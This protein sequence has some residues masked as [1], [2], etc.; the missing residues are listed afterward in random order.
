MGDNKDA[1]FNLA[2]KLI[3]W[4]GV[5]IFLIA[6]TYRLEQIIHLLERLLSR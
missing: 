5:M 2:I 6:I 3:Q 4:L 1:N